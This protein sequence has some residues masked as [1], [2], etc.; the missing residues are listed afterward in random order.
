MCHLL[1]LPISVVSKAKSGQIWHGFVIIICKLDSLILV[2]TGGHHSHKVMAVCFG[3]TS[4]TFFL[5]AG[6]LLLILLLWSKHFKLQ[7]I[8]QVPR[9]AETLGSHP[10]V[11]LQPRGCQ[12][13]RWST[14]QPCLPPV[15]P[16][17]TLK[18]LKH[19]WK[20]VFFCRVRTFSLSMGQ[21]TKLWRREGTSSGQWAAPQNRKALWWGVSCLPSAST[22]LRWEWILK[23]FLRSVLSHWGK[24]YHWGNYFSWNICGFSFPK[25][26]KRNLRD[27]QRR[28]QAQTWTRQKYQGWLGRCRQQLKVQDWNISCLSLI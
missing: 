25:L 20:F 3:S 15:L 6:M 28:A 1:L 14:G 5:P 21:Q 9:H 8:C 18:E 2:I 26:D 10:K 11:A 19:G 12:Y 23:E 17:A 13:S 22:C 27:R 16:R 24:N 7:S 4:S